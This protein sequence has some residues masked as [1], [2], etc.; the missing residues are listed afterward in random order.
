M[1]TSIYFKSKTRITSRSVTKVSYLFLLQLSLALFS[2]KAIGQAGD[3]SQIRNGPADDPTKNFFSTFPNPDWVNGNAGA[4]NAHYREG[5]SIGYRSL[6][7]GLKPSTCYEYV[8]EYD[9]Y[10][11]AMAIDYLTHFQR[12]E[13]HGPFGHSAEIIDPRIFKSGSKEYMMGVISTNTFAIPAPA[14]SNITT[15]STKNISGQPTASFNALP[16]AEKLMTIYNGV[17]NDITYDKQDPIAIS[18]NNNTSTRV[19]I[20]FTTSTSDSVVLAWGG[21]IASRLDWGF[22]T[23]TGKALSAAGISGSPY[24]MRQISMNTCT[25]TNIS[26]GNQDRS[27]AAAAVFPPPECPTV[28]SKSICLG[29]SSMSFTISNPA[30]NVTYTWS[31]GT[32]TA[33]ATFSTGTTATGTTVTVVPASSSGFTVGSFTLDITANLNGVTQTCT[34]VATG[35]VKQVIVTATAS[36][37]TIDITS[38][39][40]STTLTADIDA[41]SSDPN[42]ANYNYQWEVVTTGYTGSLTNAT[43]RIATYTAGV[44]DAGSTIEFKVTATQKDDSN[45]N[46]EECS[47]DATVSVSVSSVG[48]CDVSPSDAVCQGTVVTHT[49]S[50]NPKP[51]TATYTWSLQG[52]GGTG[53]TTATLASSNGGVS[54]DVNA[55]Q[56]YRIVLSEV[57][58][59]TAL[60]TSCYEDVV[61][62]ATPSVTAT[63]NPP[64]CSEK[65]F[66][67]DVNN[68]ISGYLYSIDQPGNDTDYSSQNQTGTG[69]KISFTGLTVGDGYTVTVKTPNANCSAT[70]ACA[71]NPT[72][73]APATV[74]RQSLNTAVDSAQTTQ[75]KSLE[76]YKIVLG[77]PTKVVAVPNPYRDRIKFNL[78]SMVSGTGSLELYNIMGQKIATV[79]EGYVQAG[80][81]F[82]KEFSV[83]VDK[84]STLIYVFKVG[85]QRIT[86]KLVGL[87]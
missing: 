77:V 76:T 86:G 74:N 54:I 60:N 85:D 4:S 5:Y 19:R 24:H 67:V 15:G 61:V 44:G 6:L 39:A 27:L 53:T 11:G 75:S 14:P 36:P 32:N 84:R 83:P 43:S 3:L 58:Q 48:T 51:S 29:T 68:S 38:T 65:T 70:D 78:L 56:S 25:G 20:K 8:I 13:P 55:N 23:S 63:Y 30:A 40:H 59:N 16:A 71:T 41:A 22:S 34:S 50:P 35:T 87:K 79:Y 18:G 62:D 33:N 2:L 69:G 52:Y 28:T 73:T 45:A 12:L 1:G 80:R 42:N 72:P 49:G 81:E 10:H 7:T 37:T 17:I 57:Y 21:H 66:T 31:F 26:L 64:S 47:D 9:T 82:T 46:T